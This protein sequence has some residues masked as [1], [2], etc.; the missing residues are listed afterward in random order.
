MERQ[1]GDEPVVVLTTGD[2]GLIA[3]AKSILMDASIDFFATGEEVQDLF[4]Y[5][6]FPVGSNV[7]TGP[8]RLLVPS[9]DVDAARELLSPLTDA[10]SVDPEPDAECEIERP[11]GFRSFAKWTAKAY[12]V[13][14]LAGIGITLLFT[15]YATLSSLDTSSW[16]LAA[17]SVPPG[18]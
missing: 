6:R 10:A 16:A 12:I 13:I 5:G 14:A 1:A 15:A 18:A 8:M 3:V 11:S 4:G 2:P 17:S 7:V 9:A